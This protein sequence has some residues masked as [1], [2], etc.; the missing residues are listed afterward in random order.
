MCLSS[1]NY[2]KAGRPYASSV[3]LTHDHEAGRLGSATAFSSP[4][5]RQE[6]SRIRRAGTISR[7][8]ASARSQRS[9]RRRTT[10]AR[11]CG[12]GIVLKSLSASL[13][14]AELTHRFRLQQPF[15]AGRF[16]IEEAMPARVRLLPELLR[17][18]GFSD[19]PL[20]RE[21]ALPD[22][23]RCPRHQTKVRSSTFSSAPIDGE[24]GL[25]RCIVALF[26]RLAQRSRPLSRGHRASYLL[27]R[28]KQ[29]RSLWRLSANRARAA[30]PHTPRPPGGWAASG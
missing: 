7:T 15:P 8:V 1:T 24:P 30:V 22:P 27:L 2:R 10:A 20:R 9:R 13:V 18:G 28:Q 19:P 25:Q 16:T 21:R 26:G 5:L 11:C 17:K 4:P 29:S 23:H 6:S 12:S 14:L 3:T